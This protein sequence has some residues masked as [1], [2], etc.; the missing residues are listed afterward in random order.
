MCTDIRQFMALSADVL[1]TLTGGGQSPENGEAIRG[2]AATAAAVKFKLSRQDLGSQR[3][4][5]T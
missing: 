3:G 5:S 4:Q 1:P 2:A